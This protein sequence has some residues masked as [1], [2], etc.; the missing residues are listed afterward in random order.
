[1]TKLLIPDPPACGRIGGISGWRGTYRLN[2]VCTKNRSG[3]SSADES[4]QQFCS[5][6]VSNGIGK[7][8]HASFVWLDRFSKRA[9]IEDRQC[10]LSGYKT[11]Q[12]NDDG[13][14]LRRPRP[15]A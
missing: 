12:S 9:Q 1:M 15:V 4:T 3:G 10:I 11:A 13:G 6:V 2:K 14:W 5:K 7:Q 8:Q